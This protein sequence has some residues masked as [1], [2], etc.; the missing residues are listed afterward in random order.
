MSESLRRRADDRL[1]PGT[2]WLQEKVQLLTEMLD[3]SRHLNSSLDLRTVLNQLIVTCA[4]VLKAEDA[5]IMLL[6]EATGELI[7]KVTSGQAGQRIEGVRLHRGEGI[8]GQ[9]ALT[10]ESRAVPD[11]EDDPD[12]SDR[13]DQLSGLQTRS[14]IA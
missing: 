14:V 6:D 4:Q 12:H 3:V 10:G 2:E 1:P 9:V 7:F 13:M 8:A 5:S 11:V